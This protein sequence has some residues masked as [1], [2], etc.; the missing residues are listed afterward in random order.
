MYE[1][2]PRMFQHF[3]TMLRKYHEL[4]DAGRC[5]GWEQEELI[6]KSIKADTTAQHHV[7][8]TE[9]GHDDKNDIMIRTNGEFHA[10]QIKSGQPKNGNL[11]I[12]GHR[13]DRFEGDLKL[14]TDYLNRRDANVLSVMYRQ[15]NDQQGRRHIYQIAYVDVQHLLTGISSNSWEKKG[16]QYVQKNKSGITFSL[17]PSMSWQ[18]WWSIPI[19]LLRLSDEIVIG[20]I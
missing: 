4:F 12:S 20:G 3:T 9:A 19:R 17:R 8:W 10:L 16:K 15:E 5:Q 13:L 6:V 1:L 2:T 18:I 7:R 14:I 11:T